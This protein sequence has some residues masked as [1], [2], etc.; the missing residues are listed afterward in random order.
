MAEDATEQTAK[1]C[2][3]AANESVPSPGSC[4]VASV[5]YMA[6]I[7]RKIPRQ[8]WKVAVDV[9]LKKSCFGWS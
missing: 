9:Q 8:A 2:I 4:S 7:F 6:T 3:V 1:S 5:F